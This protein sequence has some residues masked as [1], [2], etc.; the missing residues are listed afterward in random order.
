MSLTSW[1]HGQGRQGPWLLIN[2]DLVRGKTLTSWPSIKVD[3]NGSIERDLWP[4]GVYELPAE[5]APLGYT[6]IGETE[7]QALR[8]EIKG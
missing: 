5:T 6:N 7:F 4:I 3:L 2:A 8:F 1:L